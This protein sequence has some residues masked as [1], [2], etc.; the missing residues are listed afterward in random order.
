MLPAILSWKFL[1]KEGLPLTFAQLCTA[2]A[3]P[4]LKQCVDRCAQEGRGYEIHDCQTPAGCVPERITVGFLRRGDGCLLYWRPSVQYRGNSRVLAALFARCTW[5]FSSYEAL[6]CRLYSLRREAGAP[7]I[8]PYQPPSFSPAGSS[9]ASPVPPSKTPPASSPVPP[10]PSSKAPPASSPVPP[11]P[12]SKAPPA[13]SPGASSS[14]S[15]RSHAFAHALHRP[16]T[17]KE[18]QSP[19]PALY[20][21]LRDR[22]G[23]A[24]LGQDSAVEA[25]AYRLY[26]HAG[27]IAPVRPLSLIFYGPTGV[28]K[29]ELG[30]ALAPALES[31]CGRRFQSVWTE[32]NTF[33]QPQIG[34]AHV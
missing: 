27:K 28:G 10:V 7:A 21:R 19:W 20:L 1:L 17:R 13:S 6:A 3:E 8:L 32:L 12:S 31:C 15:A 23:Q 29:S 34:R 4:V 33:T 18:S 25:A 2:A 14:L 26:C 24:V 11:V 22:L 9:G 30:K 16:I 5:C